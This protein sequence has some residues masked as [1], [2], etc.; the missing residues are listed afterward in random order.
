M[1]LNSH[2]ITPVVYSEKNIT[3]ATAV[4]KIAASSLMSSAFSLLE[5][6]GL[7]VLTVNGKS[8]I[9]FHSEYFFFLTTASVV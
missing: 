3:C 5:V 4:N 1:E 6:T 2:L 7:L 9:R 8:L